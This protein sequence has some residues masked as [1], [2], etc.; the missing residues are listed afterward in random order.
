MLAGAADKRDFAEASTGLQLDL[1]LVAEAC[2][3]LAFTAPDFSENK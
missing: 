1:S 2:V 3:S